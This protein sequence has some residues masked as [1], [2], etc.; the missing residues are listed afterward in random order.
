VLQTLFL[1]QEPNQLPSSLNSGFKFETDA[2]F[3]ALQ[4]FQVLD[5]QQHDAIIAAFYLPNS[6]GSSIESLNMSCSTFCA[7]NNESSLSKFEDHLD[8]QK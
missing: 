7:G 4:I 2:V 8:I 5:Q 1:D 3:S 6:Y